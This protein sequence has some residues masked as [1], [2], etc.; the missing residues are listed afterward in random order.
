MSAV[1]DTSVSVPA[2]SGMR[3]LTTWQRWSLWMLLAVLVVGMLVTLVYLAARYE[4]SVA[5]ANVE[6]DAA[7]ALSDIRSALT[8]NVQELQALQAGRPGRE[9]WRAQADALLRKHRE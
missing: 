7:D 4:A 5:Q 2:P 6:R 9:A 1:A 3:R 8:R